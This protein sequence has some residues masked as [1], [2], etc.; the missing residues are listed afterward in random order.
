[1]DTAGERAAYQLA[2]DVGDPDDQAKAR[3]ML[4]LLG[5]LL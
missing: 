2:V 1:M 5:G 3:R 4:L